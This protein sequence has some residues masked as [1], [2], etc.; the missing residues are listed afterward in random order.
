MFYKAYN[1]YC[2]YYA[3][4]VNELPLHKRALVFIAE[5]LEDAGHMLRVR[6]NLP[7]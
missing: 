2:D 5:W 3:K 6:F 4:A 1:S 7:A